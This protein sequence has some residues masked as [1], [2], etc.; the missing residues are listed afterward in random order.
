MGKRLW[1][2][3]GSVLLTAASTGASAQV[4]SGDA[5]QP[6][7]GQQSSSSALSAAD[8]TFLTQTA[9]NGEAEIH[10]GK[11]AQSKG[12]DAQVKAF[13]AR[14]QADHGKAGAELRNLAGQKG[15]ALPKDPGPHAAM[16]SKFEKLEGAAFDRAYMTAMVEDHTKAVKSFETAANSADADVKAFATKTLPTIREHLSMAQATQ[17]AL[18]ASKPS[19]SQK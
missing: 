17:K 15:V 9:E 1:I 11:L 4:K 18:G 19:S 14:M 5:R 13:G 10:L 2:V 16:Q 6:A 3:I 7:A 8:R 12:M